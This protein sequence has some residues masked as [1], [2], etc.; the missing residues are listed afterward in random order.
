ML[1]SKFLTAMIVLTF[2]SIGACVAFQALEMK[3]YNL[4]ET[5]S[6]QFQGNK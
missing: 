5:I 2:L 6:K 4:F 1:N 3:E